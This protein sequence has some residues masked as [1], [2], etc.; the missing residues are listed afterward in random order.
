MRSLSQCPATPALMSVL[1]IDVLIGASSCSRDRGADP[2][3]IDPNRET[4][5][6]RMVDEHIIPPPR[7]RAHD[8]QRTRS[9]RGTDPASTGTGSAPSLSHT[10]LSIRSGVLYSCV[11]RDCR[12]RTL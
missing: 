4:E 6:N 10:A 2:P 8:L 12:E 3:I 11:N 9:G 7:H 1:L 5:R